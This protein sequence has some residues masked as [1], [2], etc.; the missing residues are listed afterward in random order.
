[1]ALIFLPYN[2]F[3][4]QQVLIPCYQQE[5]FIIIFSQVF[6]LVGICC[7]LQRYFFQLL[8]Q[9]SSAPSAQ[10][11][12]LTEETGMDISYRGFPNAPKLPLL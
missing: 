1:M 9:K 10:G 11:M 8:L 4:L 5:Q 2:S 3:I 12:T 7:F 6:A